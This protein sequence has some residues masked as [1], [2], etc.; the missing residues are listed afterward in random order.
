M[1]N[2]FFERLEALREKRGLK[3]YQ[4][5]ELMGISQ[6]VYSRYDT[7]KSNP[8]LETICT[9]AKKVTSDNL[10]YLLTGAWPDTVHVDEKERILIDLYR[11]L[12][13]KKKAAVIESIRPDEDYNRTKTPQVGGKNTPLK[14]A[15]Q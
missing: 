5:A 2:L 4:M 12:S 14:K 15:V 13:D 6:G 9:L 8:S 1:G 11:A 3:R 10:Y 7:E